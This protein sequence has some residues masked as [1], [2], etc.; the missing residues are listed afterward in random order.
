[1]SVLT[2]EEIKKIADLARMSITDSEAQNAA[3]NLSGILEH[4]EEIRSIDTEGIPPADDISGLQNVMREDVA[5]NNKLAD[6]KE[7]LKNAKTK[8]GYIEVSAVFAD[9]TVS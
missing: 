6:P 5:E 7:L 1:M 3:Q 8:N 2:T 9:Q 4:F